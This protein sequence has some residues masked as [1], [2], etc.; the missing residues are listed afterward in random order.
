MKPLDSRPSVGTGSCLTRLRCSWHSPHRC[1]V[2]RKRSSFES[3]WRGARGREYDWQRRRLL[4]HSTSKVALLK[5]WWSWYAK[6]ICEQSEQVHSRASE[7]FGLVAHLLSTSKTA[8]SSVKPSWLPSDA[9]PASAPASLGMQLQLKSFCW[10]FLCRLVSS[11][12]NNGNKWYFS[13]REP[14]INILL[15]FGLHSAPILLL[16][17]HLTTKPLKI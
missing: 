6:M 2:E 13:Q 8:L 5:S 17:L 1:W 15:F 7:F 9:N 14:S 4:W 11:L 3:G 10:E 12:W 16:N